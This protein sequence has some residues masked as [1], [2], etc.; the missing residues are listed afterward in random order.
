[1]QGKARIIYFFII[2]LFHII[3][4]LIGIIIYPL[5]VGVKTQDRCQ[6]KLKWTC[7]TPKYEAKP[8][9]AY[10]AAREL[11]PIIR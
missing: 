5:R 7:H 2:I 6:P 1:M 8:M 9:V 4:I 10:I 3:L 11:H